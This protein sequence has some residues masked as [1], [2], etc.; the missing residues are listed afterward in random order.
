[1]SQRSTARETHFSFHLTQLKVAKL[2]LFWFAGEAE[3]KNDSL[4]KRAE[5]RVPAGAQ[6]PQGGHPTHTQVDD[7][8]ETPADYIRYVESVSHLSLRHTGLGS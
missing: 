5:Q 1:V 7:A 6:E 2:F 8:P 4:F 3:P